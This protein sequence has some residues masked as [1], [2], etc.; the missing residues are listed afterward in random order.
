VLLFDESF[1]SFAPPVL[2]SSKKTLGLARGCTF[3]L[4]L[5]RSPR[6]DGDLQDPDVSDSEADSSGAS[7]DLSEEETSWISWFCS[8][9]GNEFFCEVEEDYIQDEFNLTGLHVEVPYFEYALD[10]ILDAD[11][12][13]CACQDGV[14]KCTRGR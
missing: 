8:L 13:N 6:M 14:G 9:R 1:S 4:P 10:M 2:F 11:S 5:T 7:E 12:P 3:V